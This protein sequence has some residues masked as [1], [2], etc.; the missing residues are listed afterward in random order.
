ML[1]SFRVVAPRILPALGV[2]AIRQRSSPREVP[3]LG[4]LPIFAGGATLP[5][6]HNG[7]GRAEPRDRLAAELLPAKSIEHMIGYSP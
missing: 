6:L 1:P 7:F 3:Q 2:S 5:S 4:K